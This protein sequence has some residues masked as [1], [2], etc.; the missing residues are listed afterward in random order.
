MRDAE[1]PDVSGIVYEPA[2]SP[3]NVIINFRNSVIEKNSERYLSCFIENEESNSYEF[4]PS[5]EAH[6]QYPGI[7]E[8]WKR[9]NELIYFNSMIASIPAEQKPSLEWINF[10]FDHYPPDSSVFIADYEVNIPTIEKS[11]IAKGSLFITLVSKST[12]E[13][14]II[15]W[16]DASAQKDSS[17][18]WSILKAIFY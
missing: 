18:S 10:K 6:A 9:E 16:R 17:S 3:E 7:F 15:R 12:G 2:I 11:L 1:P 5:A 14:R 4:L 13:W 8:S